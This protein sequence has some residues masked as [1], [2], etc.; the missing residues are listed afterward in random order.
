MGASKGFFWAVCIICICGSRGYSR[1]VVDYEKV[2][3]IAR[4]EIGVVERTGKNDGARIAE[5]LNYCNIKSPAPYCAAWVSWCFGQAGYSQPKTAWS[6][7]LFPTSRL[8]KEP[9][10]GVVFGIYYSG[11]GR[12]GH[13]G[14]IE[15]VRNDWVYG[16][17]AN[18][19]VVGSREGQGVYRKIRHK[20]TIAKYADWIK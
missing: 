9:K 18:T 16:L 6:P 4:K 10:P 20:R 5:Y 1:S 13:C 15:S 14:I 8:V 19:N 3:R 12:I 2:I 7:S 17:E 11:L